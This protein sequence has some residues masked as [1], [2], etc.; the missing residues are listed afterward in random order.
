MSTL[1]DEEWLAWV[2]VGYVVDRI[3]TERQLLGLPSDADRVVDVA[4][5]DLVDL[6]D[7]I[8]AGGEPGVDE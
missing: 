7:K 6:I 3:Q 2:L 4:S 1:I 8:E 5:A